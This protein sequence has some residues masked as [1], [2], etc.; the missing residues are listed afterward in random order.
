[1]IFNKGEDSS[2]ST[3]AWPMAASVP[4]LTNGH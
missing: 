4:Q 3:H 1:V 2:G